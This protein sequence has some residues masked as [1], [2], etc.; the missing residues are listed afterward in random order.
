MKTPQ[1]HLL[2][3]LASFTTAGPCC[4]CHEP[5]KVFLLLPAEA[6]PVSVSDPVLP[7]ARSAAPSTSLL[8]THSFLYF[9]WR[10]VLHYDQSACCLDNVSYRHGVYH[11]QDQS[12]SF[13]Y[14]PSRISRVPLLFW[15][16][17][18]FCEIAKNSG[19]KPLNERRKKLFFSHRTRCFCDLFVLINL[20][21]CRSG[22]ATKC[23]DKI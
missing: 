23:Q 1:L 2:I 6:T 14:C 9:P 17:R 16:C 12:Q 18:A 4:A 21:C 7:P 5:A 19:E 11:V 3:H 13:F 8:E 15:R 10:S 20:L 22:R